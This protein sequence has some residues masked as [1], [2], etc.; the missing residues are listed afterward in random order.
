MLLLLLPLPLP[1]CSCSCLLL[2]WLL[3]LLFAGC[4][5]A[6]I[7]NVLQALLQMLL[8]CCSGITAVA[9]AA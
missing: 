3:P 5:A 2:Q 7:A 4:A 6:T 8:S 9:A 1:I